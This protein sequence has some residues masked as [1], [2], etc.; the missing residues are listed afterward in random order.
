MSK[1]LP[2]AAVSIMFMS[3]GPAAG[4][5]P[6]PAEPSDG[7]RLPMSL[8]SVDRLPVAAPASSRVARPTQLPPALN[9]AR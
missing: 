6:A 1:G 9:G 3:A 8:L 5:I 2:G 7:I 4:A